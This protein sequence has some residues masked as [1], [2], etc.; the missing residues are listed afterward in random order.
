M[1]YLKKLWEQCNYAALSARPRERR[2]EQGR[3]ARGC[4]R[5]PGLPPAARRS[6]GWRDQGSCRTWRPRRRIRRCCRPGPPPSD[7]HC[8][9]EL[10]PPPGTSILPGGPETGATEV[11]VFDATEDRC[12]NK[13]H[14]LSEDGC[15]CKLCSS[16]PILLNK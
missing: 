12:P 5:P 14:H 6:R 13:D 1:V 3:A 10:L 11:P 15:N 7:R 9:P 8:H 16:Q 2:A 4:M